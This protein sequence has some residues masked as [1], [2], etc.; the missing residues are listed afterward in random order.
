M[1]TYHRLMEGYWFGP[2]TYCSESFP[3]AAHEKAFILYNFLAVYL[4]P[5]L[6]ICVCYTAM[7]YQMGHP[8]VEP[9]ENG[10]QVP[11]SCPCAG[12]CIPSTGSVP[13]A[14]AAGAGA[15]GASGSLAM[16]PD[17]SSPSRHNDMGAH[18]RTSMLQDPCLCLPG[19]HTCLCATCMCTRTVPTHLWCTH[20]LCVTYTY[21]RPMPAHVSM[22]HVCT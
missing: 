17:C 20:C 19:A 9:A 1:L 18:A 14:V 5:L 22:L 4:L 21:T 6:T 16:E 11:A 7:L 8:A 12:P 13:P 10:Y 2:Q 3:S 15:D